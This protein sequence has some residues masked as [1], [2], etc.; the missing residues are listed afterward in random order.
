MK[1]S[2][3][4]DEVAEDSGVSTKRQSAETFLTQVLDHVPDLPPEVRQRLLSTVSLSPAARVRDLE[5]IF[6]EETARG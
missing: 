4:V 6:K 3:T 2:R 1:D 5:T